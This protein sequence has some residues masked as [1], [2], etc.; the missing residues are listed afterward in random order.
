MGLALKVAGVKAAVAFVRDAMH[1]RD[2]RTTLGYVRFL[3]EVAIKEELSKEFSIAF[4][5]VLSRDWNSFNT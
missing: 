1:H 4:S 3:E 2:E 5:G